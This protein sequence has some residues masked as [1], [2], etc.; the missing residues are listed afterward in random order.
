MISISYHFTTIQRTLLISFHASFTITQGSHISKIWN[1][2]SQKAVI[3]ELEGQLSEERNLRRE[4]RDKAAQ[5]LKSAL[6]KVQAEAQEEIKRQ[7]QSY[8]RQQNEQKE[9]INKLQ[10]LPFSNV[11]WSEVHVFYIRYCNYLPLLLPGIRKRNPFACGNIEDQAGMVFHN[12]YFK[13]FYSFDALQ[14]FVRWSS[15][16]GRCSR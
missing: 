14:L 8:L 4:E 5:D 13:F 11:V 3:C 9:V 1:V 7:A 10:V 6:H 16:A 2:S 12:D 15:H